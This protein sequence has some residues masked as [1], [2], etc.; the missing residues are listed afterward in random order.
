MLYKFKELFETLGFECELKNDY[1]GHRLELTYTC[2]DDFG[3]YKFLKIRDAFDVNTNN[4]INEFGYMYIFTT[5]ANNEFII[6]EVGY[7][8]V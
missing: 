5:F 2:D 6:S 8:D 4:L 1:D 3:A 7:E